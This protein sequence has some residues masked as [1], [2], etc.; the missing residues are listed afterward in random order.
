MVSEVPKTAGFAHLQAVDV[1]AQ[2]G[3]PRVRQVQPDLVGPSRQRGALHQ[4]RAPAGNKLPLGQGF[5]IL[6]LD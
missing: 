2:D 6:L 1:V 5:T 3:V 4:R